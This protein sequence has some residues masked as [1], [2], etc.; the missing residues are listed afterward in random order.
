MNGPILSSAL[1][2]IYKDLALLPADAKAAV[3]LEGRT[4]TQ[5]VAIGVAWRMPDGW[6]LTGEAEIRLQQK[7]SARVSIGKVW[8]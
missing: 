8:R 1:N 3:V 2:Q 6:V 4:E 7:P 5:S